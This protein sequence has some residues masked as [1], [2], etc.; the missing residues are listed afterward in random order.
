ML[1]LNMSKFKE[2]LVKLKNAQIPGQNFYL[3]QLIVITV[4]VITF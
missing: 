2:L 1:S 3:I 4:N